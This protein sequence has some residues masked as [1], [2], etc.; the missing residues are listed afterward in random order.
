MP[1]A[2]DDRIQQVRKD[3][4]ALAA[5]CEPFAA[6]A[7][8]MS[9]MHEA[10]LN[11][12]RKSGLSGLMVP[13]E[14][15]GRFEEIDPLAVCV[16]REAMMR[17]SAHLDSVFALQGIGSYAISRAG[18]DA[19]KREWLP[20]VARAEVLAGLALTEPVAGSDLRGIATSARMEG[21]DLVIS[22]AKSFISNGGFAGFFTTLVKE[23]D[24][25]EPRYSLVLVPANSPG[26][27]VVPSPEI[28]APHVL[29]ELTYDDVRVPATARLGGSGDGFKH[30][31]AT[32]SVFRI[33]VAGAAC[34]LMQGA[35]EEATRHVRSREQ[36]G[37]PLLKHGPVSSLLADAWAE[38]EA[39]RLLTYATAEAARDDAAANLDRSSLAKLFATE[40]A[41]RVA[42]RCVQVMGRWGL[43]R[44]SKIEKYFR[45]A[46]PMRVYEGA[47]EVLR[48]GVAARLSREVDSWT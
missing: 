9:T 31:L 22:G 42:D 27:T 20:R 28:I 1:F 30:V 2:L 21:G 32:L 6:E 39:A 24:H 41:S 38:Y 34:G 46:R 25:D 10:T 47:S 3:A 33:S 16:A 35:I 7:D 23:I 43:V 12:L 19:Q 37:R 8:E 45:Q 29:G 44:G 48:L 13:K 14:F 18:T 5:R 4:L 36:F 15:G 11:E 17:T 40:A 26:L